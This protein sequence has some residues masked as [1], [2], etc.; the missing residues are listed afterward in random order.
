MVKSHEFI[1][2]TVLK[3]F[4]T[5]NHGDFYTFYVHFP[6]EEIH[7]DDI[8]VI[9]TR[10]DA[11]TDENGTA[12]SNDFETHLGDIQA[13]FLRAYKSRVPF[14]PSCIKPDKIRKY[15]MYQY[16]RD[17]TFVKELAACIEHHSSELANYIL[18][19][20]TAHD[21]TELK[22]L[23]IAEEHALQSRNPAFSNSTI[24]IGIDTE[25]RLLGHSYPITM[26]SDADYLTN[27][28]VLSPYLIFIQIYHKYPNKD[29]LSQIYI[30]K[31][32]SMTTLTGQEVYHLNQTIITLGKRL[33]TGYIISKD[34]GPL[35]NAI[36]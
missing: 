20:Y 4:A 21:I 13:A 10:S 23:F 17:D 15:F 25:G 24:S 9:N 28:L 11:Y 19:G 35:K 3:N 27:A 22:N 26:V 18:E 5:K 29:T 1:S 14:D 33:K 16:W 6:D 12:L 36:A 7:Y 8:D 31:P 2:K 30:N 32:T 34:K